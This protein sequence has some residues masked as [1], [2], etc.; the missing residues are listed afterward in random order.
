MRRHLI[1]IGWILGLI[2]G[3]ASAGDE[4]LPAL[5]QLAWQ[6]FAESF[7]PLIS[8][9]DRVKLKEQQYKLFYALRRQPE[10][11]AYFL[12]AA[13]T[14]FGLGEYSQAAEHYLAYQ[15]LV[16]FHRQSALRY[17]QSIYLAGDDETALFLLQALREQGRPFTLNDVLEAEIFHN[18]GEHIEAARCLGRAFASVK[19]VELEQQ[20]SAQ[21]RL[22]RVVFYNLALALR[23]LG[24]ADRAIRVLEAL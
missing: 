10:N 11:P 22:R 24:H 3:L 14:S 8:E 12:Q 18:Q 7:L 9:Q 15:R 1:I 6:G 5:D 16:P 17:V 13:G 2:P 20:S 4:K 21:A 23:E 19:V